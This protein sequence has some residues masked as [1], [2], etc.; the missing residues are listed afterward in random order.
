MTRH[1]DIPAALAPLAQPPPPPRRNDAAFARAVADDVKARHAPFSLWLGAPAL[2]LAAAGVAIVVAGPGGGRATPDA[3][4]ALAPRVAAVDVDWA[5]EGDFAFPS[6]E[7]ST[8]E[9][10]ARLDR[11][12]EEALRQR[13]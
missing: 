3:G 2:A 9:E 11:V 13:R 6:L 10:L 7:G 5:A 1:D 4:V 8:D 12:L